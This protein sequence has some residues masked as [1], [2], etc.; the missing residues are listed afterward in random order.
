MKHQVRII[1]GKWRSRKIAFGDHAG[2]RPTTDKSRERLF[3]WLIQKIADL[4]CLDLFAGSGALS[5]EALSRGAKHVTMVEQNPKIIN[6]LK[7]NIKKLEAES[8]ITLLNLKS[9]D[10]LDHP[11]IKKQLYDLIFLD[12]PF[13][14]NLINQT[15]NLLSQ[16]DLLNSNAYIYIETELHFDE[17]EIP[18]HWELLKES[19]SKQTHCFLLKEK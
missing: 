5:F 7:S 15:I 17:L 18:K 3:N 4:N 13:R 11:K 19:N 9:P 14:K 12:P 1:S 10:C 2:L 6:D 8:K 16:S